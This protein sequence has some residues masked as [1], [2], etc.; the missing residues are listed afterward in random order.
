MGV[1]HLF[2]ASSVRVPGSCCGVVWS[3]V[4]ANLQLVGGGLLTE[5]PARRVVVPILAAWCAFC[6]RKGG[7]PLAG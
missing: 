5:S 2:R 7:F 4:W 6:P 1:A 3:S